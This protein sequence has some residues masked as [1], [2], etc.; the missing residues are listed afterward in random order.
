MNFRSSGG[1][2]VFHDEGNLNLSFLKDRTRY[3]R[4]E[5]LNLVVNA[6]TSKWNIDLKVNERDDIIL[7]GFYKVNVAR[8]Q[9]AFKFNET[10]L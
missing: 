8:W 3:D 1:G 6:L 5:N 9:S 2:A 7:D 4:K 10:S